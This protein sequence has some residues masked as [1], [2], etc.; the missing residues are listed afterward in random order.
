MNAPL[1]LRAEPLTSE[2]FAPFGFVMQAPGDGERSGPLPVITDAR[3]TASVGATLIHL[4]A[5]PSPRRIRQVE[6]HAHS[7]QFFLHLQGGSLS[8]VVMPASAD[9]S[10][11][12]AAAR[13][14]IA[15]PG[16]AFGYHPG[17]WHAGVAAM[18]APATVASLLSRDGT[19]DD[20]TEIA[21]ARGIE[22]D[23][24]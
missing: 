3:S 2:A 7:Q 4:Q 5:A 24:T 11:D 8:L 18:A 1:R 10:P 12:V 21:L 9:G 13:A 6:R 16:Q 15:A 23:W 17:T 20:V 22:V 19:P 14:F